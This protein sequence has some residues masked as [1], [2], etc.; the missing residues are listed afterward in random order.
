MSV[1]LLY[2]PRGKEDVESVPVAA[3]S[4]F[5]QHWLPACAA[6]SLQWVPLFQGGLPIKK[7][8]LPDVVA[9]LRRL[10][11]WLPQA[12][13]AAREAIGDRIGRLIETL[14]SLADREDDVDIWIG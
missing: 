4:T 5:V 13:P 10:R 12:A 9:E 1:A 7:E 2:G 8:D 6:L 14:E 11:D 3:E